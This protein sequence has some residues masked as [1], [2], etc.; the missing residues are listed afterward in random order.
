MYHFCCLWCA[1]S[2]TRQF[3]K[4]NKYTNKIRLTDHLT[5]FRLQD[6][7]DK[8]FIEKYVRHLRID[9]R[10]YGSQFTNDDTTPYRI[11]ITHSLSSESISSHTKQQYSRSKF[12]PLKL[13]KQHSSTNFTKLVLLLQL[14]FHTLE[15]P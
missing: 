7:N 11:Q 4:R 13:A 9:P 14:C 8:R 1:H 10:I 5:V 6:V 12:V 3:I 2:R 15:F